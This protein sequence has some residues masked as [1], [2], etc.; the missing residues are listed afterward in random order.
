MAQYRITEIEDYE[1]LVGT[2][3]IQRIRQQA[4]NWKGPARR[5]F[6]FYVLRRWCGRDD[7]FAHFT[8]EQPSDYTPSG[9]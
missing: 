2:E 1:S 3:T 6:Q 7:F 4:A 5:D 8:H 9:E